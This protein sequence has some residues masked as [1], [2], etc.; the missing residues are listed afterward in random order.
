M[1]KKESKT[2]PATPAS[3]K[4]DQAAQD[5]SLT[6]VKELS[7]EDTA[8][9]F[10]NSDGKWRIS[11]R[12]LAE[13]YGMPFSEASRKLTSNNDL[14]RDLGLN[15]VT[16]STS[17]A[18][19]IYV[20][21]G[22]K[23]FDVNLSIRDSVSFLMLIPYKRYKDERKDKLVRMRNWLTD[24]AEKILTGESVQLIDTA[25]LKDDPKSIQ[26][27]NNLR[28]ALFIKKV[29]EAHP[30]APNTV[31]RLHALS[32]N[33]QHL[34]R[35]PHVPFEAGAHLKYSKEQAL[36]DSAQKMVSFAAI[37]CGKI[38]IEDINRF[39]KEVF[40]GLP[41]KYIPDYLPGVI[42][43]TT[44]MKLMAGEEA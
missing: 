37:A 30:A 9:R 21:K 11:L 17:E 39:E 10:K 16:P 27:D 22:G 34:V 33:D 29:N 8:L 13:Y 44:Q 28:R 5:N 24:N 31:R 25:S 35:G 32:H 36:K 40:R 15:G 20:F 3:D 18:R 19:Y 6:E 7:F 38:E 23:L 26:G 1:T 41:E 14:F 2:S 4:R 42:E 12:Q 43:T